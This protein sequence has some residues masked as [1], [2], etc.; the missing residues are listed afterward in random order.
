[1]RRIAALALVAG[2]VV[3]SQA[4]TVVNNPP[5]NTGVGSKTAPPKGPAIN[6]KVSKGGTG[7]ENPGGGGKASGKT[8]GAAKTQGTADTADNDCKGVADG[9]AICKGHNISL[10]ETEQEYFLDCNAYAQSDGWD[11]GD[12]YETDSTTDCFGCDKQNDGS[13]VCC[14]ADMNNVCCDD[15]GVCWH[16]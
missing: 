3:V 7:K 6:E 8:L 5:P 10:C 12:C 4:C 2:V 11:A 16:P 14:D 15:S 1:M 13:V 9:D